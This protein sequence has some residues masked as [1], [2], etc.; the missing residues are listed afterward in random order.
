V[1]DGRP[2]KPSRARLDALPPSKLLDWAINCLRWARSDL[3]NHGLWTSYDDG[4]ITSVRGTPNMLDRE[5][6]A[7]CTDAAGNGVWI[8][9]M[10]PPIGNALEYLLLD[11][12]VNQLH[13]HA[14]WESAGYH[15]LCS[16]RM[17]AWLIVD[18][19]YDLI[20]ADREPEPS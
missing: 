2:L 14:T 9:L 1:T 15:P 7:I 11:L 6:S 3:S 4:G 10:S 5:G 20:G 19:Y 13:G 18:Q 17:L 16:I 8:A 12:A